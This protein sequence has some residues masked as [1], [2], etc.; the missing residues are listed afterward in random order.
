MGCDIALCIEYKY[1]KVPGWNCFGNASLSLPRN[2]Q[3]FARMAGVR[4]EHGICLFPAK[5]IPGDIS[6][7]TAMQ[8]LQ[9]ADKDDKTLD[10]FYHSHSWLDCAALSVCIDAYRGDSGDTAEYRAILSVLRCFEQQNFPSRV[11]IWFYL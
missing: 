9:D 5:G 1:P 8:V 2:Y 3:M 7:Y 11:V 6:Y 4:D 10:P